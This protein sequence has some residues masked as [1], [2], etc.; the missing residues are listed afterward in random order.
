MEG[1]MAHAGADAQDAALDRE[2][3]QSGDAVDVDEVRRTRQAQRHGG[4]QGLP[5][6]Q[7]ASLVLCDVGEQ[8]DR[9]VQG[10]GGMENEGGGF[11]CAARWRNRATCSI[12]GTLSQF[13]IKEQILLPP[14]A[15]HLPVLLRITFLSP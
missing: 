15:Q 4:Y 13:W 1:G 10:A 3:V 2:P 8:G 6:G 12:I 14:L 5:A 11:H 7:N 9:I